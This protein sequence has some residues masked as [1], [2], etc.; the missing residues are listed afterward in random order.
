MSPMIALLLRLGHGFHPVAIVALIVLFNV[1]WPLTLGAFGHQFEAVSGYQ[2]IDLQNVSGILSAEEALTQ[3]ATY[4]S[5]AR[6][7]Y[8]SFFI[9]DNI[10]P[11]L[12]FGAFSL[13]WAAM[14]PRLRHPFF[15][16]LLMGPFLLLPWGVGLFD[17]LENLCFIL[18]ISG[19]AGDAASA[20]MTL[21]LWFVLLKAVCLSA[22]F[23]TT[24]VLF[25]SLIVV[26]VRGFWA[27][28][29]QPA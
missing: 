28:A 21:G 2:P 4:S 6:S 18:C 12:S 26:Q 9:L 8:W 27:R 3:I 13:L 5:E 10:V 22:T 25:A 29:A 16:N 19:Y 17:I 11:L 20:T 14:L 24:L 1:T 7:L 23:M 15:Q